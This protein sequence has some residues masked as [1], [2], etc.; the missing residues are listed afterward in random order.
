MSTTSRT[1]N[2]LAAGYKPWHRTLEY[3]GVSS[4][5]VLLIWEMARLALNASN[6]SW[7]LL[8]AAAF[9]G[10]AASDVVSGVVHWA[11]D[12]WFNA[13][14]PV[15]GALF[16]RP[17]REHHVNPKSIVGHDF[18]EAN[19]HNFMLGALPMTGAL[20]LDERNTWCAGV[21]LTLAFL[22]FF[23]AMTSQ[24]HK[25]AHTASPP[26]WV[27]S[28]QRRGLVLAPSHHDVHHTAPHDANYCITVGWMNVPL[29][30][31]DFFRR[32]ERVITALTGLKPRCDG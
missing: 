19:G 4:F 3:L 14:M 5:C 25:W 26:Q 15:L 17:F 10:I 12:T 7:L 31:I 13:D 1:A 32:A 30:R 20:M 29:Q 27:Q 21:A 6:A 24:I 28:L 9:V 22:G 11:C 23:T 16:L 18:F 8:P 2:T